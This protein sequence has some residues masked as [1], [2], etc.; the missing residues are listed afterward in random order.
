MMSIIRPSFNIGQYWNCAAARPP[1]MAAF[2]DAPLSG[3]GGRWVLTIGPPKAAPFLSN[4]LHHAPAGPKPPAPSSPRRNAPEPAAGFGSDP[5]RF[6]QAFRGIPEWGPC[7]VS[8][9]PSPPRNL[10]VMGRARAKRWVCGVCPFRAFNRY[11]GVKDGLPILMAMKI[12]QNF[13]LA[14]PPE[15]PRLCEFMENSGRE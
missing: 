9:G 13:W 1:W 11:E 10:G 14:H 7:C 15:S 12:G 6:S 2:R 3:D 5:S 8:P 4:G